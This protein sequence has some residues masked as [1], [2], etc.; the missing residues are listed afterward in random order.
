MAHA[1]AP[2]TMLAD[3]FGKRSFHAWAA[4]PATVHRTAWIDDS[5]Q[6]AELDQISAILRPDVPTEDRR[7]RTAG[8]KQG[9]RSA[10]TAQR[11][12]IT[13]GQ[14]IGP[15]PQRI[16]CRGTPA[17]QLC[18]R[19]VEH[20]GGRAPCAMPLKASASIGPRN[21]HSEL[22]PHD[23][24]R[25]CGSQSDR[26]RAW[27]PRCF[28]ASGSDNAVPICHHHAGAGQCG[29]PRQRPA[30]PPDQLCATTSPLSIRALQGCR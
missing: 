1:P 28:R 21:R 4:P 12:T 25:P 22:R 9:D 24:P 15:D 23:P 27:P 30:I 3:S 5:A 13:V 16:G 26:R 29:R 18:H 19:P 14:T 7:Q 10:C 11:P 17:P 8:G 6:R 2:R 20:G